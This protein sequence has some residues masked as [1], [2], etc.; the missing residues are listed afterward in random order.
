LWVHIGND[1]EYAGFSVFF[2]NVS[3][4]LDYKFLGSLL[5]SQGKDWRQ[6]DWEIGAQPANFQL[7]IMGNPEDDQTTEIGIDDIEF[8]NCAVD[9]PV[10][11]QITSTRSTVTTTKILSPV[12]TQPTTSVS[13]KTTTRT[14]TRATCSKDYCLN[15]GLCYVSTTNNLECT[16]VQ[17]FSGERCELKLSGKLEPDAS[18]KKFNLYKL[19]FYLFILKII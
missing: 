9:T 13:T 15:N 10:T 7:E 4:L 18:S 1:Q 19:N 5:G 2:T 16:C 6:F 3:N 12:T 11:T 17:G 8:K 14:T